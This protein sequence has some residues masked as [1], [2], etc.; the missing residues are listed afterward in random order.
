MNKC[1]HV[2]LTQTKNLCFQDQGHKYTCNSCACIN[3]CFHSKSN[4]I[5]LFVLHLLGILV[6]K[7]LSAESAL[8]VAIAA[9]LILRSVSDIWMIQN[10]TVIESA[11]ITMN[12]PKFRT[13]LVKFLAAMPAVSTQVTTI[14]QN[15]DNY[16]FI[17]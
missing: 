15:I 8:L 14:I 7:K 10:A 3:N 13:S 2:N 12:K 16:T 17:H 6:P 11:I 5:K 9:S 4:V 1:L